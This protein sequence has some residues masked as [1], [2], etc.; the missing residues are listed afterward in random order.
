[1]IK[2]ILTHC[3]E[4]TGGYTFNVSNIC[5]NY[6]INYNDILL[7]LFKL[8]EQKEITYETKE[9]GIFIKIKKAFEK[10]MNINLLT[11]FYELNNNLINEK[12]QKLNCV[13]ILLRK[14]SVNNSAV[15][16]D[17]ENADLTQIKCL[18]FCGNYNSYKEEINKKICSYFNLYND[19]NNINNIDDLYAGNANEKDILLP[20]VKL[21]TQRDKINFIN[22]LKELIKRFLE[23][24]TNI[25]TIDVMNV[26]FGYMQKGKGIKNYKSHSMWNKYS[27]YDYTQLFEI[28]D[29]ELKNIK[30]ELI[31]ENNSN[32]IN[33]KKLKKE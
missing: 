12:I 15:F 24:E 13:Y 10:N 32:K 4:R 18:E 28:V 30:V 27:N 22:S 31:N 19:K 26:L 21:D 8:Q 25:S 9:D 29:S 23:Y 5:N 17:M 11:Y 3:K 2:T 14:Y 20:I 16:H 33:S 7:Y 6:D 1:L